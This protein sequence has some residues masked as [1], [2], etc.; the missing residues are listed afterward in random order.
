VPTVIPEPALLKAY[1]YI[2][3]TV[4]PELEVMLEKNPDTV[5]WLHIPGGVVNLPVVYRDNTYYLDRD[6]YGRRSG[7]GTLFLDEAHPFAS[8][9]QYMVVHGHNMYD[10]SMFGF[11]SHYRRAGYMEEHP[12]V[13]L[14]TLY[15]QEEYEVIG[16]LEL[17][18]SVA[19]EGYVAYTGTRKFGSLEQF[20]GFAASIRENALF[21][22]EDA[23]MNPTDSLLAL[24]TCY[25]DER[26]VVMCRREH[27]FAPS[28]EPG[29]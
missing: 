9:T 20:Y 14:S 15:R 7:S 3:N 6:F 8:D 18:V 10:G 24:S 28:V 23:E 19:R 29:I 21:W 25:E 22:K 12:T 2:G 16:V 17:P 11:V 26:I 27:V 1:Q 4:L 13:Y 5:L